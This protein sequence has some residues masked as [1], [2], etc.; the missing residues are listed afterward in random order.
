MKIESGR[1]S[2]EQLAFFKE[3]GYFIAE[4]VFEPSELEPLRQ[5]L[6]KE[7]ALKIDEL[8]RDGKIE[9]TYPE[10]AFNQRLTRIYHDNKD[11]GEEVMLSLVGV[12]GGRYQGRSMYNLITHPRLLEA[13]SSLVGPDV[14]ASAAYRIR[15]KVPGIG[16]G[17]VPWHRDSGYFASHC[18]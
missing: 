9:K 5:D 8:E 1:L 11:N 10:E 15:P 17:D 2:D 7:I 13:V 3:E 12:G 16:R 6:E 14:V 4:N 18:E